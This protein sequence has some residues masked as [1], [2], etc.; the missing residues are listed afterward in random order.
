MS[1]CATPED[2]RSHTARRVV[3]LALV[4]VLG[5]AY[6]A[7]LGALLRSRTYT[8][9]AWYA[10]AWR[11]I[12][13]CAGADTSGYAR[14][15]FRAVPGHEF[16]CGIKRCAGIAL[17]G[18]VIIIAGEWRDAERVVRHEMLHQLLGLHVPHSDARF[19]RCA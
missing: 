2:C 1:P 12:A 17:P 18:R 9:P 13:R 16:R 11:E 7:G 10:N 8:P 15:R 3:L 4:V 19:E 14:L 6:D 5:V